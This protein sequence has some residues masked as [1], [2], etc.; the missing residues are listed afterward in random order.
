MPRSGLLLILG[1][2]NLVIRAA[3]MRL[4]LVAWLSA[5]ALLAIVGAAA[6]GAAFVGSGADGDSLAMALLT[7]V[8]LPCYAAS[9]FVP[10]PARAGPLRLVT[11][12]PPR[13]R[14]GR[15]A[16]H[17]EISWGLRVS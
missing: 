16:C 12:G 2:V 8:A 5:A 13:P 11:C 1:A 17:G 14:S 15:H 9:L 4:R 3:V 7:G 6:S 10:G